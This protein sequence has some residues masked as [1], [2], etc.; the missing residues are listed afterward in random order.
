MQTLSPTELSALIRLLD[1]EDPQVHQHVVERLQQEGSHIVPALMKAWESATD[2]ILQQQIERLIQQIQRDE[3]LESF[4]E[5]LHGPEKD[6]L[7]GALLLAR[8]RYPD[9]NEHLVWNRIEQMKRDIWME[10]RGFLSPIEKINLF[11]HVFYRHYEYGLRQPEDDPEGTSLFM[12]KVL[13]SRKGN[14]LLLG[15]LYLSL[16]R[17]LG[18]HVYAVQL[19]HYFCLAYL[20]DDIPDTDIRYTDM[21]IRKGILFYINPA[22]S[23][24]IF[25]KQEIREYL[26]KEGIEPQ[27]SHFN[28]IS[29]N[30][31]IKLLLQAMQQYYRDKQQYDREKDL[32]QF[33][34][35]VEGV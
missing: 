35:L 29:T 28:P 4:R 22:N 26:E 16:A 19:P 15:I 33:L 8:I 12:N 20:K 14:G 27:P 5:W 2:E 6:L 11:N 17:Q 13:E 7:T 18:M 30:A 25:T 1:D 21:D 10:M 9:F 23:G 34:E 31:V 24:L 32:D 3:V